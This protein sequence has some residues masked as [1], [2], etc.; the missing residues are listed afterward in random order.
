MI[1][2]KETVKI[3]GMGNVG[4]LSTCHPIAPT[5]INMEFLMVVLGGH[6]KHANTKKVSIWDSLCI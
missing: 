2:T 5:F 6:L 3:I 1:I 4:V